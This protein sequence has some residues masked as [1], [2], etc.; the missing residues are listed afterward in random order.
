MLGRSLEPTEYVTSSVGY[1]RLHGRNYD[2]WFEA[3]NRDDRYNY[4][5]K[6]T[7][8]K[9]WTKKIEGVAEKA[10]KTYVI[11]NNHFEGKAGVNALELKS[12]LSGKRV[13]APPSLVK[14]YPG[15]KEVCRPS[16]KR[17]SQSVVAGVARWLRALTSSAMTTT[18]KNHKKP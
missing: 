7:E 5:Y 4:L 10:T 8:L 14:T 18:V 16:R 13:S 11:T 1:V 12:L 3:D 17:R 6:E 9:D 15:T 2:Q